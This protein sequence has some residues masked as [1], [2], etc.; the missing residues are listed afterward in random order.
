MRGGGRSRR[1][2]GGQEVD[3]TGAVYPRRVEEGPAEIRE[4]VAVAGEALVEVAVEA[5]LG[6][7]HRAVGAV[8]CEAHLAAG[9][10]LHEAQ[11][12]PAEALHALA[13]VPEEDGLQD[14]ENPVVDSVEVADDLFTQLV[15][16]EIPD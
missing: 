15:E 12:V 11:F 4:A 6:L 14:L 2:V 10:Y 13:R 7:E 16:A 3:E 1:E 8:Q 9:A 5:A